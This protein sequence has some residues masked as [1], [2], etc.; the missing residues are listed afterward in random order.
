VAELLSRQIPIYQAL[1]IGADWRIIHGDKDFFTI[2]KGFHNALQGAEFRLTP[3]VINDYLEHNRQSAEALEGNYDVYVV[4]DPQPAAV[5]HFVPHNFA[6]WIWRC[7]IDTS[8][9]NRS[10]GILTAVESTI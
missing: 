1:G 6:K 7:H 2:T 9:P 4:H 5:R 3:A 10:L 8:E